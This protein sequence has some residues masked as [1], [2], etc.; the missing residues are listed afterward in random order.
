MQNEQSVGVVYGLPQAVLRW[1]VRGL[2]P[3]VLVQLL[4]DLEWLDLADAVEEEQ[5]WCS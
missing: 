1:D 3:D 5:R 2:P 4:I